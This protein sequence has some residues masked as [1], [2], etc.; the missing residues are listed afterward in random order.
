MR[1]DSPR[2]DLVRRHRAE[3]RLRDDARALRDA[4]V[5]EQLHE[6][7]VVGGRREHPVVAAAARCD[8]RGVRLLDEAVRR[9]RPLRDDAVA[10][11][12]RNRVAGIDHPERLEDADAAEV[13]ERSARH[14]GDDGSEDRGARSV[15]EAL[16]RIVQQR[17]VRPA[18]RSVVD[19]REPRVEERVGD[20]GGV[21][22]QIANRHRPRRRPRRPRAVRSV[23]PGEHAQTIELRQIRRGRRVDLDR[24]VLHEHHH[25]ERRDRLRHRCDAEDRVWRERRAVRVVAHAGGV[26]ED[27][28]LGVDN[29]NHDRR[30]KAAIGGSI[31]ELMQSAGV[32]RH[33]QEFGSIPDS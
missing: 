3:C 24:A 1:A 8:R 14:G 23:E 29:A 6:P 7:Q 30:R 2:A 32:H 13:V 28:P 15:G 21:R 4:A 33:N 16:A 31:D 17:D 20:A 22:Q 9:V 26:H 5:Q 12:G 10:L 25:G 11:P 18:L 19:L 27:R